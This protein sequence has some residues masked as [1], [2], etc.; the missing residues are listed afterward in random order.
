MAKEDFETVVSQVR[1]GHKQRALQHALL[2]P[3]RRLDETASAYVEWH[4]FVLWVRAIVERE[5]K[6][7]E[8]VRVALAARCPGF[9]KAEATQGQNPS[10]D[11]A[12]LWHSL[13]EWI[14]MHFFADAKKH[15]W[16]DAVMFYAYQD[17]RADQAWN[18]WERTKRAWN[19]ELPSRW[20][21]FEEWSASVVSTHSL[22]QAGSEKERA[23]QQ[24]ANVET[25]RL[26]TAV[27]EVLEARAFSLWLVCVSQPKHPLGELALSE[28]CHRCPDFP[29]RAV[30]EPI[31]D[32]PLFFRLVRFGEAQWRARAR[33]ERWYAALRYQSGHHPRHHRLVH[34]LRRCQEEWAR[35]PPRSYPSF[36]DWL[37]AADE[38]FVVPTT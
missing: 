19:V 14:A 35:V 26:R 29:T 31:W 34:Y 17:L 18:L 9:L 37:N 33:A 7:P 27:S 21:T 1:L 23:V 10:N 3:W 6:L 4:R 32:R 20:P 22:G 24:L 12:F 25:A 13:E 2:V 36:A 16:F 30:A 11:R 8:M 28:L 5:T 15:G 38:Y